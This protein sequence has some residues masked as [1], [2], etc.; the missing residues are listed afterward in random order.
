MNVFE[1]SIEAP[2]SWTISMSH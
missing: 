1:G 2:I